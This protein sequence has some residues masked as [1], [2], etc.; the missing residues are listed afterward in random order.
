MNRQLILQAME[1]DAEKS[2][3]AFNA[4]VAD[5]LNAG[6]IIVSGRISKLLQSIAS[7]RPLCDYLSRETAGYNF[8]EEFRGRQFRD[9]NGVPYIDVPQDDAEKMRFAFCLLY[10]VDTGK[11]NIENLL[12][13][14]Y[15][16]P[17]PNT[18]L[19]KFCDEIVRPFADYINRA[20]GAPAENAQVSEQA[21]TMQQAERESAA[22]IE[23][24]ATDERFNALNEI[25]AEIVEIVSHD[26]TLRIVHREELLL[27]C[28]AFAAAVEMREY[29]SLRVMYIALKNTMRASEIF[30]E[31]QDAYNTLGE[32]IAALGIPTD[33]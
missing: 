10:A 23:D 28:D 33:E 24:G 1:T 8:V 18:E 12:H 27:V 21:P 31:L 22:E 5:L 19:H 29:K 14:F 9:E 17:D 16:D 25:V 7:S 4:A 6:Y 13:M 15:K 20:F 2:L 11:L 32:A 26:I 3:A 30:S